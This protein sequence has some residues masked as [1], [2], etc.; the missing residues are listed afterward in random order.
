MLPSNQ[1]QYKNIIAQ[2]AVDIDN[3]SIIELYIW[4]ECNCIFCCLVYSNG[5]GYYKAYFTAFH[6][7]N[8]LLCEWRLSLE[9]V[10]VGENR[11]R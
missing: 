10:Y 1:A 4:M 5:A 6:I 3:Y 8:I 2:R 9:G 7:V 11:K